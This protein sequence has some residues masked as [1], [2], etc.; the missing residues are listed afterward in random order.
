MPSESEI[1]KALTSV[2]DPELGRDIVSLGFVK[3]V[4]IEAGCVSLEIE[5]TTPA[6]PMRDRIRNEIEEAVGKLAGVEQVNIEMVGRVRA[7]AGQVPRLPAGVKNIVAIASGK[8][9]VGKSTVSCNIACALASR[10]ARVGLVDLDAYGPTIPSLLGISSEPGIEDG[11]IVPLEGGGLKVVSTGFFMG[12]SEAAILR[13]P[14]LHK[15]VEQFLFQVK[16][17]EL[18]YLLADLPPGT[19]DV[20]LS[21]C[22]LAPVT[23]AVIVS[24]PQDIALD[25][26]R[27]AVVLFERLNVPVLGVIE[28]MSY[29]VCPDCGRRENIFGAGGVRKAAQEAGWPILGEIPLVSAIREASDLGRP[30]VLSQERSQAAEAFAAAACNLAAQISIRVLKET[31]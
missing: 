24:T 7:N 19:G 5:L 13:G 4:A 6:C 16:W 11:K 27:K 17:G 18:D 22:Q 10:G 9:G 2:M 8:G 26:A 12:K 21:L 30:T 28:N 25:V 31:A 1:V 20:H 23:G 3:R 29:F 14:M 15:L